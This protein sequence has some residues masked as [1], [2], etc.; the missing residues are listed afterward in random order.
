MNTQKFV[1]LNGREWYEDMIYHVCYPHNL[2]RLW[3]LSL[4]IQ[5]CT[6][7]TQVMGSNPFR[8]ECFFFFRL[9]FH[10]CFVS[11][12]YSCNDQLCPHNDN[13]VFIV[14]NH[15]FMAMRWCLAMY[16]MRLGLGNITAVFASAIFKRLWTSLEDFRHLQKFKD[17]FKNLQKWTCDVRK[18]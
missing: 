3:N 2:S 17:F 16:I 1:Y 13:H 12:V 6:S 15:V 4:K 8:P 14:I 7:I 10:N 5:A 9:G 11:C 18:T